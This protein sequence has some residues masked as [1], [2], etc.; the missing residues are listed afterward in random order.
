MCIR[1]RI[2]TAITFNININVGSVTN[3]VLGIIVGLS[4]GKPLGIMMFSFIATKLNITEK[5][6]N[7][8]WASLFCV[9][10]LAGIG[11]T[12]S[13]FVSEIAFLGNSSIIDI[14]KISI[15]IASLLSIISTCTIV[16]IL[17]VYKHKISIKNMK[18]YKYL[19]ENHH[20]A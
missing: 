2:N 11:F 16:T 1:D 12:M 18:L 13:I 14:S 20:S 5:P 9:S 10:T 8:S 19:F 7:T 3:L 17:D 4:V 15:L 6:D